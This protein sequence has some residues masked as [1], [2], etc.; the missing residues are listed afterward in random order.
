MVD[1]EELEGMEKYNGDIQKTE[2]CFVWLFNDILP[3][4]EPFNADI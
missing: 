3:H 2:R 4:Y 1:K